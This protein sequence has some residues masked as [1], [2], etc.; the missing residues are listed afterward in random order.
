[1]FLKTAI[2]TG[3][4]V[5]GSILVPVVSHDHQFDPVIN[6]GLEFIYK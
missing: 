2:R 3:T 6:T 4:L 1:M 5:S